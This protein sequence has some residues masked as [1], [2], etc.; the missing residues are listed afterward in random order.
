MF[1]LLFRRYTQ[2]W[3]LLFKLC[4][5]FWQL[6]AEAL[7]F[8]VNFVFVFTF[9]TVVGVRDIAT[10]YYLS[11]KRGI[12]ADVEICFQQFP[13]EDDHFQEQ[14]R[15]LL[16]GSTARVESY[17]LVSDTDLEGS[18]VLEKIISD[19]LPLGNIST[20][21]FETWIKGVR[22][23]YSPGND[24]A[25][26]ENGS[27][28]ISRALANRYNSQLDRLVRAR[29]HLEIFLHP[30]HHL[31]GKA[32]RG[33]KIAAVQDFGGENN[34]IIM[35]LDDLH[36]LCGIHGK[37]LSS[38]DRLGIYLPVGEGALELQSQLQEKLQNQN[39]EGIYTFAE[40][41]G[42][43]YN[44]KLFLEYV[45]L[46]LLSFFLCNLVTLISFFI[47]DNLHIYRRE[48]FLARLYNCSRWVV[49]SCFALLCILPALMGLF[50]AFP[51][52]GM[53]LGQARQKILANASWLSGPGTSELN[54]YHSLLT[55]GG[56]L[57]IL[58]IVCGFLSAWLLMYYQGKGFRYE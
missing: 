47:K 1:S 43:I 42:E 2:P 7:L 37:N 41:C 31:G 24:V 40:S 58:M 48:F 21:E 38:P 19:R 14:I 45:P 56:G 20:G 36:H 16:K 12:F 30:L 5:S 33:F 26:L 8:L 46:L 6:R 11:L 4:R 34:L 22:Q 32:S 23:G 53:V 49:A 35:T 51:V 17:R 39:I 55:A 25:V 44:I 18:L 15:A 9:L 10:A 29:S 28:I 57:L 54:F 13:A 50:C 52:V 27:I 3:P